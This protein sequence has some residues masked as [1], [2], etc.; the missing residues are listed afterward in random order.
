MKKLL[1]G[2]MLLSLLFAGTFSSC[3][4]KKS[5]KEVY[6]EAQEAYKDGRYEEAVALA[7]SVDT[8]ALTDLN[9]RQEALKLRREARI[10]FN[11]QRLER[12]SKTIDSCQNIVAQ[13]K[14]EMV[15]FKANELVEDARLYYKN[16][17]PEARISR[18]KIS[19]SSDTIGRIQLTSTY[20]GG[21]INHTAVKLIDNENKKII[22]T[23]QVNYDGGL[24]YRYK[25]GGAQYEI[26]TYPDS[27]E[28]VF[29]F[30]ENAAASKH[31]ITFVYISNGQ[32]L[33][34]S[35]RVTAKEA[36]EMAKTIEI[37][38][39]YA[40]LYRMRGQKLKIEGENKYLKKALASQVNAN[41]K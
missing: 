29:R 36:E 10:E 33:K 25:S 18:N 6:E 9:L 32:P 34:T 40:D 7:K 2:G 20:R 16:F 22:S 1:A 38:R 17:L 31:S 14:P 37:G 30:I 39:C 35:V 27:I 28:N 3:T 8:L 19:I 41:S 11:K 21:A 24:N 26:V 12:L 15:A 13:I 23:P 4:D 5:A